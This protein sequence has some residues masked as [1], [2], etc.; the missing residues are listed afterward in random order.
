M[1]RPKWTKEQEKREEHRY[2]ESS[3]ENLLE[4]ENVAFELEVNDD[5]QYRQYHC[6]CLARCDDAV[7]MYV[8]E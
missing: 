2:H 1:T 8:S 4:L 5:C 7:L 6:M 3:F